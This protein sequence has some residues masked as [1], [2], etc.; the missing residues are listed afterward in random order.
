MEFSGCHIICC[1]F[2]VS[3]SIVVV[4]VVVVVVVSAARNSRE[5]Q[6]EDTLSQYLH[7]SGAPNMTAS[8]KRCVPARRQINQLGVVPFSPTSHVLRPDAPR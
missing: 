6:T 1:V 4:V 5:G 2:A 3:I 7:A 8:M